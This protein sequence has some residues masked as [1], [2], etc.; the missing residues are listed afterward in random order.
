MSIFKPF[1]RDADKFAVVGEKLMKNYLYLSDELRN[2]DA[3]AHILH[4]VFYRRDC[5]AYEL[6]EMGGFLSFHGIIPG[7]KCLMMIKIWNTKLWKPSAV[8][9]AR[10]IFAD[11]VSRSRVKRISIETADHHMVKLGQIFGFH[12]EGIKEM[13]F[14]WDGELYDRYILACIP[15]E[16]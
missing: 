12:V 16:E 10:Q 5:E 8:K 2:P 13:D 6:G 4:S 7:H 9:E 1:E 3:V 15:K 11:F 14:K